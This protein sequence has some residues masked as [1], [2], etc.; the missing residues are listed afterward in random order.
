MNIEVLIT[1]IIG[2]ITT[3]VS[4][5]VSWFFTRK[6]YNAEVDN[7]IIESMKESLEFYQ[8]LSDDNKKRLDTMITRNNEL[9]AE[10]KELRNQV[11]TLKATCENLTHKLKLVDIEIN[12]DKKK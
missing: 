1:A 10:I 9:E 3:F 11:S 8:K 5:W 2:I 12:K 6:K 4:G 7:T